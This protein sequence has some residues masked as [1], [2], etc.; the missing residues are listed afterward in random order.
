M[1][2]EMCIRDSLKG[3]IEDNENKELENE[4]TISGSENESSETGKVK[5]DES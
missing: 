3:N 4:A 2:S 1:G 5:D